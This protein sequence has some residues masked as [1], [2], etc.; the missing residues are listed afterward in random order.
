MMCRARKD[1]QRAFSRTEVGRGQE[2]DSVVLGLGLLVLG[3]LRCEPRKPL[4]AATTEF[5]RQAGI[6]RIRLFVSSTLGT[7]VSL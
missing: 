6:V 1:R 7:V 4:N 3:S 2:E 5:C